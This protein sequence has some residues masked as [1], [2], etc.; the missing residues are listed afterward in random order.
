MDFD[1]K[2]CGWSIL[3]ALWRAVARACVVERRFLRVMWRGKGM[4]DREGEI[5]GPPSLGTYVVGIIEVF[6]PHRDS[7]C[8]RKA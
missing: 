8:R 5:K 4:G 6:A 2:T 3:G 1:F 7:A